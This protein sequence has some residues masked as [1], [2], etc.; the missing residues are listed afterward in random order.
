[1]PRSFSG[2]LFFLFFAGKNVLTDSRLIESKFSYRFFSFEQKVICSMLFA[3][4]TGF[5]IGTIGDCKKKQ[6]SPDKFLPAWGI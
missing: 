1:M 2:V 4:F 3:R 6:F 5:E